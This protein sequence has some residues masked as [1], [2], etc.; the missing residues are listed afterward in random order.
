MLIYR[1]LLYITALAGYVFGSDVKLDLSSTEVNQF[2]VAK[3][4]YGEFET[5]R[6]TPKLGIEVKSIY[7]ATNE[8]WSPLSTD[9]FMKSLEIHQRS[10]HDDLG[11]LVVWKPN[12]DV[13]Q[14]NKS[15]LNEN[16]TTVFIPYKV[17]SLFFKKK[18]RVWYPLTQYHYDVL[19]DDMS[20]G[21][22]VLNLD[23]FLG[24]DVAVNYLSD[25]V[26]KYMLKPKHL[27]R[28]VKVIQRDDVLWKSET[29]RN[30][31]TAYLSY[32]KAG[33][34]V[35]L[36]LTLSAPNSTYDPLDENSKRYYLDSLRYYSKMSRDSLV[37]VGLDEY[38]FQLALLRKSAEYQDVKLQFDLSNL[39][40]SGISFSKNEFV[41]RGM[42]VTSY[43]TTEGFKLNVVK[44]G[45][46]TLWS[47]TV[48][49]VK[50]LYLYDLGSTQVLDLRVV[51]DYRLGGPSEYLFFKKESHRQWETLPSEEYKFLLHSGEIPL[52]V[53]IDISDYQFMS[54][55]GYKED[56]VPV[57]KMRPFNGYYFNKVVQ[58]GTL[59]WE[60]TR[61]LR[62]RNALIFNY[63]S[64]YAK[65]KTLPYTAESDAEAPGKE[66]VALLVDDLLEGKSFMVYYRRELTTVYDE[67]TGNLDSVSASWV[68]MTEAEYQASFAALQLKMSFSLNLDT[69]PSEF[70]YEDFA[71]S[72]DKITLDGDSGSVAP[73]SNA[74]SSW[75]S[76]EE[77][78][79]SKGVSN[80]HHKDFVVTRYDYKGLKKIA[81]TPKFIKNLTKVVEGSEV[82][83]EKKGGNCLS[84]AFNNSPQP[85][86]L[87]VSSTDVKTAR[88]HTNHYYRN[89]G[90]WEEVSWSRYN[91][92][93]EMM[94]EL[95]DQKYFTVNL[96]DLRPTNK[97]TYNVVYEDVPYAEIYPNFGYQMRNLVED[98]ELIW[99][100]N[101]P[102]GK[103]YENL[104]R[105]DLRPYKDPKFVKLGSATHDGLIM[106]NYYV[107]EEG[108][109]ASPLENK[110]RKVEVHEYYNKLE[111]F[112]SEYCSREEV[113]DLWDAYNGLERDYYKYE[114]TDYLGATKIG[115]VTFNTRVENLA[116]SLKN[117]KICKVPNTRYAKEVMFFPADSPTTVSVLYDDQDSILWGPNEALDSRKFFKSET[118]HFVDKGNGFVKVEYEDMIRAFEKYVS[119]MREVVLDLGEYYDLVKE[120]EEKELKGSEV[121]SLKEVD[122]K[123]IDLNE[124]DFE[125]VDLNEESTV[126]L[127][128]FSPLKGKDANGNTTVVGLEASL[129]S[130]GVRFNKVPSDQFPVSKESLNGGMLEKAG[131]AL[132]RSTDPLVSSLEKWKKTIY[133]IRLRTYLL[134]K[135]LEKYPYSTIRDNDFKWSVWN[136]RGV[137]FV[138]LHLNPKV[139]L[140]MIVDKDKKVT[141][142][143]M[144]DSVK[145]YFTITD[146]L[147]LL[148]Y[149]RTFESKDIKLT[150]F[151]KGEGA[152]W[153]LVSGG[154]TQSL[155]TLVNFVSWPIS[156][157]V[158]HLLNDESN[159][160][161]RTYKHG[162]RQYLKY[163]VVVANPGYQIRQV[164]YRS[165]LIYG[166][167]TAD[168]EYGMPDMS[169]ELSGSDIGVSNR[170]GADGFRVK[171][172]LASEHEGRASESILEVIYYPALR[173]RLVHLVLSTSSGLSNKYY[174]V[175]S[176]KDATAASESESAGSVTATVKS[177]DIFEY[178]RLYQEY[179]RI[180]ECSLD[181][182][183][184]NSTGDYRV[185]TE[186]VNGAEY[187]LVKPNL[188]RTLVLVTEGKKV[189]W[190]AKNEKVTSVVLYPK[191][192]PKLALI[193]YEENAGGADSKVPSGSEQVVRLKY[194]E[195]LHDW[196]QVSEEEALG[197]LN[198][199]KRALKPFNLVLDE[200]NTEKYLFGLM[201][202]VVKPTYYSDIMKVKYRKQVLFNIRDTYRVNEGSTGSADSE[203]ISHN[204]DFLA[205]VEGSTDGNR[206]LSVIY[207]FGEDPK[208]AKVTYLKNFEVLDAYFMRRDEEWEEITQ[209]EFGSY[210]YML[211]RFTL[212]P[213]VLDV[214]NPDPAMF[215]TT[216]FVHGGDSKPSVVMVRMTPRDK[217]H[218]T[219]VVSRVSEFVR[220]TD[221]MFNVET[222]DYTNTLFAAEG[223]SVMYAEKTKTKPTLLR[224]YF[225]NKD[226]FLQLRKAHFVKGGLESAERSTN[227]S[228]DSKAHFVE[229][230]MLGRF[231][232]GD[233]YKDQPEYQQITE[234]E[235]EKLLNHAGLTTY[236]LDSYYRIMSL[237]QL[238]PFHTK[239]YTYD[240]ESVYNHNV[241][242]VHPK[243]DLD[244]LMFK[245]KLVWQSTLNEQGLLV[246]TY[247]LKAPKQA[248]VKSLDHQK[249]KL[250]ARY[251]ACENGEWVEK[252]TEE[253]KLSHSEAE[254]AT[255]KSGH[256]GSSGFGHL[257]KEA[258]A[259][260]FGLGKT[261][262]G[263][264]D[265][266]SANVVEVD[267]NDRSLHMKLNSFTFVEEQVYTTLVVPT[268]GTK[269]TAVYDSGF[270]IWRPK[271]RPAS[272]SSESAS[273]LP[274]SVA[275]STAAGQHTPLDDLLVL[276]PAEGPRASGTDSRD[277]HEES[278][279]KA[280]GD[281][282]DDLVVVDPADSSASG[283]GAADRSV[284]DNA[285]ASGSA[286]QTSPK[287]VKQPLEEE[288]LVKLYFS[289]SVRPSVLVVYYR[290]LDGIVRVKDYTKRYA[291]WEESHSKFMANY[292]NMLES[293]VTLNVSDL[294]VEVPPKQ[295][296]V[297]L[298][299]EASDLLG[300]DDMEIE[301]KDP[302]A[303]EG[304]LDKLDDDLVITEGL[305]DKFANMSVAD[306][307]SDIQ[308]S[309]PA[310]SK[311]ASVS[312]GSGDVTLVSNSN[313]AT[314]A[315]SHATKKGG[316][317]GSTEVKAKFDKNKVALTSYSLSGFEVT[318]LT[319]KGSYNFTKVYANNKEGEPELLWQSNM[320][321]KC[322]LMRF[323]PQVDPKVVLLSTSTSSALI[324]TKLYYRDSVDGWVEETRSDYPSFVK[325]MLELEDSFVYRLEEP[326]SGLP[327]ENCDHEETEI[328]QLK[329]RTCSPKPNRKLVMV[330][331]RYGHV[332]ERSEGEHVLDVLSSPPQNPSFVLLLYTVEGE[333]E[334]KY[335]YFNKRSKSELSEGELGKY[336]YANMWREVDRDDFM[337]LLDKAAKEAQAKEA[338]D[339]VE[340]LHKSLSLSEV[341]AKLFERATAL[342]RPPV[343][344]ETEEQAHERVLKKFAQEGDD[345]TAAGPGAVKVERYTVSTEQLAKPAE[346]LAKP[347]GGFLVSQNSPEFL[348][349]L[350]GFDALDRYKEFEVDLNKL[351]GTEYKRSDYVESGISRTVLRLR[352][353]NLLKAVKQGTQVIWESAAQPK[354]GLASAQ[355]RRRR[356][357][358]HDIWH[359]NS[360]EGTVSSVSSAPAAKRSNQP[361]VTHVYFAPTRDPK[362]LTLFFGDNGKGVSSMRFFKGTSWIPY[363]Y[364]TKDPVNDK[365]LLEATDNLVLD[366]ECEPLLFRNITVLKKVLLK[367]G[368]AYH[369]K[370][371][372]KETPKKVV[373][374]VYAETTLWE[375]RGN[376]EFKATY[377]YPLSR[378]KFVRIDV[379]TPYGV[380][381][382]YYRYYSE[383]WFQLQESGYEISLYRFYK[384][385]ST[386]FVE[387]DLS[388]PELY[389]KTTTFFQVFS[390]DLFELDFTLL[391]PNNSYLFSELVYK[392]DAK[393]ADGD[394]DKQVHATSEVRKLYE[395]T[396]NEYMGMAGFAPKD[397]PK[398]ALITSY[399][400]ANLLQPEG[401]DYSYFT[402]DASD[403]MDQQ[404]REV[405]KQV[406]LSVTTNYYYKDGEDW[407]M[408]DAHS[409]MEMCKRY[410]H[411]TMDQE[412]MF[413]VDLDNLEFNRDKFELKKAEFCET[414]FSDLVPKK[415][416]KIAHV[417]QYGKIV[418]RV[419]QYPIREILFYPESKARFLKFSHQMS[420]KLVNNYFF[421]SYE[422]FG[423]Y[424]KDYPSFRA[425]L[426]DYNRKKKPGESS[427]QKAGSSDADDISVV[428]A[429]EQGSTAGVS[430]AG[431]SSPFPGT[432]VSTDSTGH[433]DAD[434]EASGSESSAAPQVNI[435]KRTGR[436][437]PSLVLFGHNDKMFESH[438]DDD[439]VTIL[440]GHS[441]LYHVD[442]ERTSTT[443]YSYYY[444]K[445][446]VDFQDSVRIFTGKMCDLMYYMVAPVNGF[447]VT[448]VFCE[449]QSLVNSHGEIKV[450]AV[451]SVPSSDPRYML[452]WYEADAGETNWS[453][454]HL[455][456]NKW[457]DLH[458]LPLKLKMTTIAKYH[459]AQLHPD[460][461]S[462]P[463]MPQ[464]KVESLTAPVSM[465]PE[466]HEKPATPESS[467][468]QTNV[469]GSFFK[470]EHGAEED[471]FLMHGHPLGPESLKEKF[472]FK[473]D[474]FNFTQVDTIDQEDVFRKLSFYTESEDAYRLVLMESEDY[475]VDRLTVNGKTVFELPGE[476]EDAFDIVD[477][478]SG[479]VTGSAVP[480]TTVDSTTGDSGATVTSPSASA[481][482]VVQCNKFD[483]DLAEDNH[484]TDM[485]S[486]D[487]HKYNGY[488]YTLVKVK[489]HNM[490]MHLVEGDLKVWTNSGHHIVFKFAFLPPERPTMLF[491]VSYCTVGHKKLH[492]LFYKEHGEWKVHPHHHAPDH[493]REIA[494]E[495]AMTTDSLVT[496]TPSTLAYSPYPSG[497]ATVDSTAPVVEPVECD[498]FDFDLVR[499]HKSTRFFSYRRSMFFHGHEYAVVRVRQHKLLS[500]VVDGE[501]LVW[502][503]H[504][505]H[506]ATE[507]GLLPPERPTHVCVGEYHLHDHTV[508]YKFLYK[509][510]GDWH[511]HHSV[512][513]EVLNV[514]K[515]LASGVSTD[516][517][518]TEPNPKK[519][520][521]E[522]VKAVVLS[523]KDKPYKMTV[524]YS[525]G[526]HE[527]YSSFL[528]VKGH[529][530]PVTL[531]MSDELT[532]RMRFLG[533][534]LRSESVVFAGDYPYA[535]DVNTKM[536]MYKYGS[537]VHESVVSSKWFATHAPEE[538]HIVYLPINNFKLLKVSF[539]KHE[540]FKYNY[541]TKKVTAVYLKKAEDKKEAIRYRE[542]ERVTVFAVDM[543]DRRFRA[544]WK[545][546]GNKW[547]MTH[548]PTDDVLKMLSNIRKAKDMMPKTA[549]KTERKELEADKTFDNFM[550]YMDSEIPANRLNKFTLSGK[551]ERRDGDLT[552]NAYFNYHIDL[553]EMEVFV[554][555][556]KTQFF[557][558]AVLE[559]WYNYNIVVV[560]DGYK[561]TVLKHLG[562]VIF[563]ARKLSAGD[564]SAGHDDSAEA[565]DVKTANDNSADAE[566]VDIKTANDKTA[567][568]TDKYFIKAVYLTPASNPYRV[569]LYLKNARGH[570]K[571]KYLW[572][573]TVTVPSTTENTTEFVTVSTRDEWLPSE[574]KE[575]L[576]TYVK[577]KF[578][579]AL[580]A[581]ESLKISCYNYD[582]KVA[583]TG[584]AHTHHAEGPSFSTTSADIAL[585]S[586]SADTSSGPSFTTYKQL[587]K[588][589]Y[590][591]NSDAVY[592][593][594]SYK[595]MFSY[596][597]DDFKVLV[598]YKDNKVSHVTFGVENLFTLKSQ[599]DTVKALL[600]MPPSNPRNLIVYY[601]DEEGN[602]HYAAYTRTNPLLYYCNGTLGTM[603]R[604]FKL[605]PTSGFINTDGAGSSAN[606]RTGQSHK[607][608]FEGM[609][610][611][612]FE[613]PLF[614]A[615]DTKY[616]KLYP[617]LSGLTT[618]AAGRGE[619]NAAPVSGR[620]A[621]DGDFRSDTYCMELYL[622]GQF[623]DIKKHA[624]CD[625]FYY[626]DPEDKSTIK[627]LVDDQI[628][629]LPDSLDVVVR[630]GKPSSFLFLTLKLEAKAALTVSSIVYGSQ[631]LLEVPNDLIVMG[632]L[633]S[634]LN[635]PKA[636][637][638][639]LKNLS[640]NDFYYYFV[641]KNYHWVTPGSCRYNC[642]NFMKMKMLMESARSELNTL[643]SESTVT[644]RRKE[645]GASGVFETMKWPQTLPT[646]KP[647]SPR[648]LLPEVR[649]LDVY[650][651]GSLVDG[652]SVLPFVYA[653]SPKKANSALVMQEGKIVEHKNVFSVDAEDT[654]FRTVFA[655]KPNYKEYKVRDFYIGSQQLFEVD[656]KATLN[657]VA[658]TPFADPRSVMVSVTTAKGEKR[659]FY[660]RR[661][662]KWEQT[663]E[664]RQL[665][666]LF[667]EFEKAEADATEEVAQSLYKVEKVN[668]DLYLT[669]L[670]EYDNFVYVFDK[671]RLDSVFVLKG[672]KLQLVRNAVEYTVNDTINVLFLW[673]QLPKYVV[674][675]VVSSSG[676]L[677]EVDRNS[678]VVSLI[679]SPPYD[680]EVMAVHEKD[681][682]GSFYK[683]FMKKDGQWYM[684]RVNPPKY[685]KLRKY[686]DVEL[687]ERPNA[688]L[689]YSPYPSG[690]ATVDSTAPV[691]EPV[692]CDKFDFDLVRDHKSTR[693]FSYRRSMFFHGHEYA[694]VRVRQHKLLSTVVDGELLVW[695]QHGDHY[696]TELGLLPPERPTHVCVGE[697]HLHDHTVKYKFLYKSG[698]DWHEF[699]SRDRVPL[700]LVHLSEMDL[701]QVPELNHG[702]FTL[703]LSDYNKTTDMYHFD[704]VK[705]ESFRMGWG[706]VNNG[707]NL[708]SVLDALG[709][710]EDALEGSFAKS[711]HAVFKNVNNRQ[712]LRFAYTPVD[713]PVAFGYSY[714]ADG[715]TR[716]ELYEKTADGWN[717]M[718]TLSYLRTA[719]L[720]VVSDEYHDKYLKDNWEAMT[721]KVSEKVDAG[722]GG[723]GELV[724]EFADHMR[725]ERVEV[726][727]M[728][729]EHALSVQVQK[730]VFD[731][732]FD[733]LNEFY[734]HRY[735]QELTVVGSL[736]FVTFVPKQGVVVREVMYPFVQVYS[737]LAEETLNKISVYPRED[738]ELMLLHLTYADR[739][740]EERDFAEHVSGSASA[741]VANDKPFS[742]VRKF[743][744][745][746][747]DKEEENM[748]VLSE[749]KFDRR[750][751]EYSSIELAPVV[752]EA[753]VDLSKLRDLEGSD[754]YELVRD[755]INDPVDVLTL[756]PRTIITKLTEG[757]STVWEA[758]EGQRLDSLSVMPVE[759]PELLS[760][761]SSSNNITNFARHG[762][763]WESVTQ[764]A[765]SYISSYYLTARHT[766]DLK[767]VTEYEEEV[768]PGDYDLQYKN[769]GM[770]AYQPRLG[771]VDTVVSE[772]FSLLRSSAFGEPKNMF[773]VGDSGVSVRY[774]KTRYHDFLETGVLKSNNRLFGLAY[775]KEGVD[776]NL[777]VLKHHGD[778]IYRFKN[779]EKLEQLNYCSFE[780]PVM[781]SVVLRVEAESC[782]DGP[783]V[784]ALTDSAECQCGSDVSD[785]ECPVH[786]ADYDK[787][788][789][790]SNGPGV[791]AVTD[792]AECQ[793]GSDVSDAEC[794]VHSADYDKE[795]SYSNGPGVGAVTDSAECQC[796]SDVSDAECPVHSADYDKESSYTKI[797]YF[798]RGAYGNE[799]KWFQV[800]EEHYIT[801]L[802]LNEYSYSN[803]LGLVFGK[804]VYVGEHAVPPENEFKFELEAASRATSDYYLRRMS[805]SVDYYA[806]VVNLG[807]RVT[808]V[809]DKGVKV[810]RPREG[811]VVIDL[812]YSMEPGANNLTV[813][814]LKV[815]KGVKYMELLYLEKEGGS[816]TK[817]DTMT[818][819]VKVFEVHEST[820]PTRKD[821][822][823][824][825]FDIANYELASPEDATVTAIN[826]SR[827]IGLNRH[828]EEILVFVNEGH[829]MVRLLDGDS[830]LF[831]P[832]EGQEIKS[833]LFAPPDDPTFLSVR[834]AYSEKKG[835]LCYAHFEKENGLWEQNKVLKAKE[836]D[837]P[838]SHEL[839]YDDE[840]SAGMYSEEPLSLVEREAARVGGSVDASPAD[841][842]DQPD[843]YDDVGY[844]ATDLDDQATD[845]DSQATDLD[846]IAVADG[847][848]QAETDAMVHGE[849]ALRGLE[850]MT[851]FDF[852]MLNTKNRETEDYKLEVQRYPPFEMGLL[853]PKEN[854]R[855]MTLHYGDRTVWK[856]PED[857]VCRQ[858]LFGPLESPVFVGLGTDKGNRRNPMDMDYTFIQKLPEGTWRECRIPYI[859]NKKDLPPC[860]PRFFRTTKLDVA[861]LVDLSLDKRDVGAMLPGSG[862]AKTYYSV[863]KNVIVNTV[864]DGE[865]IVFTSPVMSVETV[866]VYATSTDLFLAV[867]TEFASNMTTH[868]YKSSLLGEDASGLVGAASKGVPDE[869][870]LDASVAAGSDVREERVDP[871]SPAKKYSVAYTL[872]K[873]VAAGSVN[874]AA[875]GGS[876]NNST[877]TGKTPDFSAL[878]DDK[879]LR[880]FDFDL[881]EDNRTT[882]NYKVRVTE[883]AHPAVVVEV[884]RSSVLERL[885][886]GDL[887]LWKKSKQ[888]HPKLV[889]KFAYLPPKHP[890]HLCLGL[891]HLHDHKVKYTFF[892]KSGRVWHK[893]RPEEALPAGLVATFNA[894]TGDATTGATVVATDATGARATDASVVA[895]HATVLRSA[896][897]YDLA[898]KNEST[899]DYS[900]NLYQ[901]H[902]SETLAVVT[903]K[904]EGNLHSVVDGEL[905][906]W[907]NDGTKKFMVFAYLPA[908]RPQHFAL[909]FYVETPTEY[910][911][912]YMDKYEG[913]WVPSYDPSNRFLDRAFFPEAVE[914][915]SSGSDIDAT[916]STS[917]AAGALPVATPASLKTV[918]QCNKFDFDLA[919]DNHSTDMYSVDRHK[920][921]G[922]EY[923][924]VKVKEHNMLMH[925]VEGDLKV[926]TNSGHHIVF[927]FAF[928]PP[929]RPTMLFMVSYCTVGHKKLH[930]LFYKEHGEWKVHPHHHDLPE[931]LR[932]L[933]NHVEL[934]HF[935]FDLLEKPSG[936]FTKYHLDFDNK[937]LLE[938]DES[939]FL[940][941][942]FEGENLVWTNHGNKKVKA[943]AYYPANEPAHLVLSYFRDDDGLFFEYMEKVNGKWKY[944]LTP[945]SLKE[946]LSSTLA[947][948]GGLEASEP[949]TKTMPAPLKAG[950]TWTRIETAEFYNKFMHVA[951]TGTF[952]NLDLRTQPDEGLYEVKDGFVY[953]KPIRVFN[954]LPGNHV[955]KI[956]KG[957]STIWSFLELNDHIK[958]VLA[959]Y[960]K[961]EMA[962][963][964]RLLQ[965]YVKNRNRIKARYFE[966]KDSKRWVEVSEK[967]YSALYKSIMDRFYGG[968][969]DEGY[970]SQD[971]DEA[972]T[973]ATTDTE[974]P[975]AFIGAEDP[976]ESRSQYRRLFDQVSDMVKDFKEFIER[977]SASTSKGDTETPKPAVDAPKPPVED[978]VALAP[979]EQ[980]TVDADEKSGEQGHPVNKLAP[981]Q[982]GEPIRVYV[983]RNEGPTTEVNLGYDDRFYAHVVCNVTIYV[984]VGGDEL[985]K[986]KQGNYV[987]YSLEYATKR[988]VALTTETHNGVVTKLIVSL[989]NG[990]EMKH[991]GFM[992]KDEEWE[993]YEVEG[994][995]LEA[996]ENEIEYT[997]VKSSSLGFRQSCSPVELYQTL[998][999]ERIVATASDDEHIAT[1000]QLL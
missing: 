155:Q 529:W 690:A 273:A 660:S 977:K 322:F 779:N 76:V 761:L 613:R 122:L 207:G 143:K 562:E 259:S 781:V 550:D 4:E 38:E 947:P 676:V 250:V 482:P 790:Y 993:S 453:L 966:C 366:V 458:N 896:F 741:N 469:L 792:S 782:E 30:F 429:R 342:A 194:T 59:V 793:C 55:I 884:K 40:A 320:E 392:V 699:A 417:Y 438:S 868:Y 108:L 662:H 507:L 270:E 461:F 990:D 500:T 940:D 385:L 21:D 908:I 725:T 31:K 455:S 304:R 319:P 808:E 367:D 47:S 450:K 129:G 332:Y 179:G 61:M 526:I 921:N 943:M 451:V 139:V 45:E 66:F 645:R 481:T 84:V 935:S 670:V 436:S 306:D 484:S 635:D 350:P 809:T 578:A 618:V 733:M 585:F 299:D 54:I 349:Q 845:L 631:E 965:V 956:S 582:L 636:M 171:E 160:C 126:A 219:K 42:E 114:D 668:Y 285:T 80:S 388:D 866:R 235:F 824:F 189:L 831:E 348:D 471:K 995:E 116:I 154:L 452:L 820:V 942:V 857:R 875:A 230:L 137:D 188:G 553:N 246:A 324:D 549:E 890:G 653:Y 731:L 242:F 834:Y 991:I 574:M 477:A 296:P 836:S 768:T 659:S 37:E 82:I 523:P 313:L 115:V 3:L 909:R 975:R 36:S 865:D 594:L 256:S 508:K 811:Q 785:A 360:K 732:H 287:V 677:L 518:A 513:E 580:G 368:E 245:D 57:R 134:S 901:Y 399:S 56:G 150:A 357:A 15:Q 418:Y 173:P 871:S 772:T 331:D 479:C 381:K 769:A 970:S 897:D 607:R 347:L 378:P 900:V 476:G 859:D 825:Y 981:A 228:K 337:T 159:R 465:T 527:K 721:V 542:V 506:Y 341:Q 728:A 963:D 914:P 68:E 109:S 873:G 874:V 639:H 395:A 197:T 648:M 340:V 89:Q 575:T 925:L 663:T 131:E 390:K 52:V 352:K 627:L 889:T 601:V 801:A 778:V 551:V 255:S 722:A 99:S 397:D 910:S 605:V 391:V 145:V 91:D 77:V 534:K 431:D 335:K 474:F 625:F 72:G 702:N 478:R 600:V 499:D 473:Y 806:L 528:R 590:Y 361:V 448:R 984:P 205:E 472:G 746:K 787:E 175:S 515:F 369:M 383:A 202:T 28:I 712:V 305:V 46:H 113:V 327:N 437:L 881:S 967:E 519:A 144:F 118:D 135:L 186:L 111:S 272:E 531:S 832:T 396:V 667:E 104:I 855:L 765:F 468:S 698:G 398:F 692:E 766:L 743:V 172:L 680:P 821:P 945:P 819:P 826:R 164:Y 532:A 776:N 466:Q 490:L 869:G 120:F 288:E 713:D 119:P 559:E 238:H 682:S 198:L 830:L 428:D 112:K 658:W 488:E 933:S 561:A 641:K 414:S 493:F 543:E 496:D 844:D 624:F 262:T 920:Y 446:S 124:A 511:S 78:L 593:N 333:D 976:S 370:I 151:T 326:M 49:S 752:E 541:N 894:M 427:S 406:Y 843:S 978:T 643:P 986:V 24:H 504:G 1:Q 951:V 315:T 556:L 816:W 274:E 802:E 938:L 483:F 614:G 138:T 182:N 441:F 751:K 799:R 6:I 883:G 917:L 700:A 666:S 948:S 300:T 185:F 497:A 277:A 426:Y 454:Y 405:N 840:D 694:V 929:E 459:L 807:H 136:Y 401:G 822:V 673:P 689:A 88:V 312:S 201:F 968:V 617:H 664:D 480:T 20:S 924:L 642:Y 233:F 899:G 167:N 798:F 730:V 971:E 774:T 268:E 595:G 744:L 705:F 386:D 132:R 166:V 870:S 736:T 742:L 240:V 633:V 402:G 147:S 538:G 404:G 854:R 325:K 902:G 611:Q 998:A 174:S 494:I 463:S 827:A 706:L 555:S 907:S 254:D 486:V 918:V 885:Y 796:G 50:D 141:T 280:A 926:W 651:S 358:A 260:H 60:S 637:L 334:I 162:A 524:V 98:A 498:K 661:G 221:D 573:S 510:G 236:N 972:S 717:L 612:W 941:S 505:D 12:K 41:G 140:S 915:L 432:L 32:N 803:G 565:V 649:N 745:V 27:T 522:T 739:P 749:E 955:Y 763:K 678:M 576:L 13:Y 823:P 754:D 858:M 26:T 892:Y 442:T 295:K 1000:T 363:P 44:D 373:K 791:G 142:R 596:V 265:K 623:Y 552:L 683:Y 430:R 957:K 215:E 539:G 794:P 681:A 283:N 512:P 784:G 489:E 70:Y 762:G 724:K 954:P 372:M 457:L 199:A 415:G 740:S 872:K 22:L 537:F 311:A 934:S 475:K 916:P 974:D 983:I 444:S 491:M 237:P 224:V 738:P 560:P 953:G 877:T 65:A 192:S 842:G 973:R 557:N 63:T 671:D 163:N 629:H 161:F 443:A 906:V 988:A 359:F 775:P 43:A 860:D 293:S 657:M 669:G 51:K 759:D 812:Y 756:Y 29:G 939:S 810:F 521:V 805:Q 74:K 433:V 989:E 691:V 290:D 650:M 708:Y 566:A 303:E 100:L 434:D 609:K 572:R 169:A 727:A 797:L 716:F 258:V 460:M 195:S 598:P 412:T 2:D 181:V 34:L 674:T 470:A 294:F 17:N 905:T 223:A 48:S 330:L 535:V 211:K 317:Q 714:V 177:L 95:E 964:P 206:V 271:K 53:D 835:L 103:G 281:V 301:I 962:S 309:D 587:Y 79:A 447:A 632:I 253:K 693:F 992:L 789:S 379:S 862:V 356:D 297:K 346:Q 419:G 577:A 94:S 204:Q 569:Y 548:V 462:A 502:S 516:S 243:S 440:P 846:D 610:S 729:T 985:V 190:E 244:R 423:L 168:S 879:E 435:R 850:D 292:L 7:D 719:L 501:L 696:A 586:G 718:Y 758:E 39:P 913:H 227:P 75:P 252:R 979:V 687:S 261:T 656:A 380:R 949:V 839:V 149:H 863:P 365:A 19:K 247:P 231:H 302:A 686:L 912:V 284:S 176:T 318:T 818:V 853:S 931:M 959:V 83:W 263:K 817:K 127:G 178:S 540:L 620:S 709:S 930:S 882:K 952:S 345:S 837:S 67:T 9:F 567:T 413:D 353:N 10:G 950:R 375:K 97:Y 213:A 654:L 400:S 73:G 105:A 148:V 403:L 533:S 354:G 11:H 107:K 852:D 753:A 485:Y 69:L 564:D 128:S 936:S 568:K 269:V 424:Q 248:M 946:L 675:N 737:L 597:E 467:F 750:V 944:D 828:A 464:A 16:K 704:V 647:F 795:S 888:K 267:V 130:S 445:N 289:P 685:Y 276:D 720:Y 847:R 615:H 152:S 316:S 777:M 937:A 157:D 630:E 323:A 788:S 184:A 264:D 187:S 239:N 86:L 517:T 123:E 919:E 362:V 886:D 783:A 813:K 407:Y 848:Q 867:T 757:E 35:L 257:L 439:L 298:E 628:V 212:A 241:K 449:M 646:V 425:E 351:V 416:Y 891:Y 961:I 734:R 232:L 191:E 121:R 960:E 773:A 170:Q 903:P 707:Y 336:D 364:V 225:V 520:T 5:T 329:F 546:E 684:P 621:G 652:S 786:S 14:A 158:Y 58:S 291:V 932:G 509:S 581:S 608:T 996:L 251:F 780:T 314:A 216:E 723:A 203:S 387:V 748:W 861:G 411:D 922:Y 310:E 371:S 394:A 153:S 229:S 679:M 81:L 71:S 619:G 980:K 210:L 849:S 420:Q 697:Y 895:A 117:Q 180:N 833:I 344:K 307:G 536:L 421:L 695:S 409:F 278:D 851:P 321:E 864:Y 220:D 374:V 389:K 928:L 384:H 328:S 997:K 495:V 878:L 85:T 583:A 101:N 703:I 33:E 589:D 982:K 282:L 530:T 760:V 841:L 726:P 804:E 688:T 102:N 638:V 422:P 554:S 355:S 456:G 622:S 165:K 814:C 876:A 218:V 815:E 999:D 969:I 214:E 110:W 584:Q 87:T 838:L 655:L 603:E 503:Q 208:M 196:K 133:R 547:V 829:R 604:L 125:E 92:L 209:Q 343:V 626:Y 755:V 279:E 579:N 222:L 880:S 591:V 856:T 62:C 193:Y 408:A 701:N 887:L 558:Y 376:E 8:L 711:A 286:V 898:V 800:D 514:A 767:Y 771:D 634:P 710:G 958:S 64:D 410:A 18:D 764:E 563:D 96:K 90:R 93:M 339:R 665:M 393:A 987:F 308:V 487:R 770:K 146:E 640:G 616:Y 571:Y 217:Y 106:A 266:G 672:E 893:Y 200:L 23:D 492:S 599:F 25:R 234:F 382:E 570:V 994:R 226:D 588:F 156:L 249:N 911:D 545:K 747:G 735:D 606:T 644:L 183:A 275:E 525:K 338:D 602:D 904:S 592:P 927:K 377:V 544:S 715:Q 923:T